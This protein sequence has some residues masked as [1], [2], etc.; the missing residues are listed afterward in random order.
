MKQ[1]QSVQTAVRAEGSVVHASQQ[2]DRRGQIDLIDI[3]KTFGSTVAVSHVSLRVDGGEFLALLGPSGSGKTT[4]LN[5]VAGFEQPTT[6]KVLLDG[7]DIS[8]VPPYRRGIGMVFQH[9]ALFPHMTVAENVA[10]PLRMRHV[11]SADQRVRVAEALDLVR[12]AGYEARFPR[13]LSGGQQQ[14]VALARAIVFNPSVLLMDEP[15]GALDRKLRQHMQI[16]L[17]MLQRRLETTVVYVTHDQEE[18][19]TM[20]DRV[21]IM[22]NGLLQQI[23]SPEDLYER[24]RNPFVADFVGETNFLTGRAVGTGANGGVDVVLSDG[25]VVSGF[26]PQGDPQPAAGSPVR[27]AVRPERI[28]VTARGTRD[29]QGIDAELVEI[30]YVGASTSYITQTGTGTVMARV[31]ATTLS[32]A[33]FRIGDPISLCWT[34]EDTHVY[35]EGEP[36]DQTR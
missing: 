33:T 6:G 4:L 15:L 10:F 24:P 28:S 13:Q 20:A 9:Y 7:R 22:R 18:A 25:V 3:R 11:S 12:L 2:S 36:G 29:P 21:A 14:R 16:E 1:Q 31:P 23:G 26:M 5:L 27:V 8:L 17:R 30:L 19:L 35:E 34:S 32:S